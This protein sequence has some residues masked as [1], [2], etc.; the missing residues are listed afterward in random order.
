MKMSKENIESKVVVLPGIGQFLVKKI[1]ETDQPYAQEPRIG[2]NADIQ[3]MYR[4]REHND[5]D[6][7]RQETP[8]T[9]DQLGPR[10]LDI[11]SA[12]KQQLGIDEQPQEPYRDTRI[13]FDVD[14]N[15]KEKTKLDIT[16]ITRIFLP[17]VDYGD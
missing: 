6:L 14:I 16:P 15:S 7:I 11:E 9:N 13:G 17:N 1:E 5:P 12:I 10:Y 3:E 2:F 4:Q 8:G